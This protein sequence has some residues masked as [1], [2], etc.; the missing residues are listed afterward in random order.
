[1]LQKE[2]SDKTLAIDGKKYLFYSFSNIVRE[3]NPLFIENIFSGDLISYSCQN[4]KSRDLVSILQNWCK[5]RRKACERCCLWGKHFHFLM[6]YPVSEVTEGKKMTISNVFF[7][8][9]YLP[10]T[11]LQLSVVCNAFKLKKNRLSASLV[12]CL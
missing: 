3:N 4:T 11:N 9:P 5:K 6:T 12:A 8:L 2:F 10:S 1:M 7:F